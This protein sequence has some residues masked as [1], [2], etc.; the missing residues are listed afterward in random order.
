MNKENGHLDEA[1]ANFDS[2]LDAS[3]PEMR[4]ARV[5]FQPGLRSDQR[6]RADAVRARK[7]ERDR[8]ARIDG[9]RCSRRA[10]GE[11]ERTLAH[12]QRKRHRALRA[13]PD[14]R[15][16]GDRERAA[17]HTT[18]HARY[19]PDENARDRAVAIARAA[20]P[21]ANHAAQS[22]V[23]YRLDREAA[24]PTGRADSTKESL[25]KESLRGSEAQRNKP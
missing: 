4:Q 25:T 6:A 5:R 15:F 11:F 3:S 7:M 20:N 14:L 19:K 17:N 9:R 12:R 22:I 23:I 10:A 18:L 2:V 24:A 16:A 21:A 1:I 13:R 8:G